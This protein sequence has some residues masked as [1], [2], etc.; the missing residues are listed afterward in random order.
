MTRYLSPVLFFAVAVYLYWHNHGGRSS[1]IKLP[2]MDTIWPETA[3]SHAAQGDKTVIVL[4]VLG[5][6]LLVIQS[7]KDWR[8]RKQLRSNF[9]EPRS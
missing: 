3:N 9:Q 6:L 5:V 1:I 2:M 4:I 8:Y 7:V